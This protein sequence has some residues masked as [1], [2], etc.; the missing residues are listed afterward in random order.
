MYR[1]GEALAGAQR[2]GYALRTL[3]TVKLYNQYPLLTTSIRKALLGVTYPSHIENPR[4][5]QGPLPVK[6]WG[7]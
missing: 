4:A 6:V 1:A 5:T 7:G 2:G 3:P